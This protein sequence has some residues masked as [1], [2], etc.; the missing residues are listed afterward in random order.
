[1]IQM[2]VFQNKVDNIR[3]EVKDLLMHNLYLRDSDDKLV[4]RI[5]QK[6]CQAYGS[7]DVI[8]LLNLG[9]LSQYKTISRQRRLLQR[10]YPNLR[11]R[12]Y[13]ERRKLEDP[14]KEDIAN[15]EGK[16]GIR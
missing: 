11:G 2:N 4:A 10:K 14:I 9:K 1:M 6:E 12:L 7:T 5:W 8:G 16:G 15:F 3:E 13:N